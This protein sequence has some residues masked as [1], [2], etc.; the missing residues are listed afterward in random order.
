[1]ASFHATLL[2]GPPALLADPT[3]PRYL[4]D[5]C[6]QHMHQDVDPQGRPTT[7][8]Y[9]GEFQLILPPPPDA[10]LVAWAKDPQQALTCSLVFRDVDGIRPSLVLHLEQ[11]YCVSYAEH[12]QTDD[13]GHVAFFVQLSITA[14]RINKH[15][16]EFLSTWGQGQ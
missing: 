14:A 5:V 4:V 12:F 16:T 13:S 3:H 6:T 15:G 10:R 9:A 1:M 2:L 11:A 7:R 8:P